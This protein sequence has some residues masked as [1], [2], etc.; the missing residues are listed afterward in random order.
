MIALAWPVILAE[1]G[2]ISMGLVDV[3]AVG[4]LGPAA[5]GAV[6]T[7]SNVFMALMVLGSLVVTRLV[8][9]EPGD[10]ISTGTPDGIG[11]FRDPPEF[12][13]PGDVVTID[14]EGIGE[15]T[16]PVVAGW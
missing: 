10:V 6:G 15:L 12:L 1:I 2:W 13:Q 9:L 7:G 4:P 8:T 16:N 5:I 14:A 11:Y 3:V